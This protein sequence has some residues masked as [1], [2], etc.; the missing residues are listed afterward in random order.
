MTTGGPGDHGVL[1]IIPTYN[2]AGGLA[3]VV[4]RVRALAEAPQVLIVDDASP[5]GTGQLADRLARADPGVHVLHRRAK[6]GL[7]P[8]YL[9]GFA[10]ALERRYAM[11]CQLDADG[12][13]RP[14]QLP[15]LLATLD[16][17]A[18][19]A[20][21]SRW[22]PGGTIVNWSWFRVRLSRAGT[23]YARVMLG[24][25]VHDVTA[26]F[27]AWRADRLAALDLAAVS[28]QGYC[29]QIDMTRRAHA[30]G[31]TI[32]ETPIEF[33]ER[34]HGYSK[35][36]PRI[37]FEAVFRVTVWGI[38][39]ARARHCPDFLRLGFLRCR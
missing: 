4:T 13:H 32:V 38:R 8:A 37:V 25:D 39:R 6:A 27:R 18:D 10:W 23:G 24:L 22:I 15:D 3:A 34:Q 2:E 7:G 9:A 16:R 31:L 28:S 14:E 1:V 17:G 36:T 35:M 33:I 19:L 30:A 5:D 20:I 12:S 26:G 11:V 29:F 21:G